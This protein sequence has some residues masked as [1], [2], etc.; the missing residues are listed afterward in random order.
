M[1]L[2]ATENNTILL[3]Q[4]N[5]IGSGVQILASF[6]SGYLLK[7][8]SQISLMMKSTI[9]LGLSGPLI[10]G[11]KFSPVFWAV[12]YSLTLALISIINCS[13]NA[14]WQKCSPPDLQGTIFG[15]RRMVSS[16]IAPLGAL[17]AG[18][19]LAFTFTS[20]NSGF[21]ESGYQIIFIVSGVFISLIGVVGSSLNFLKQTESSLLLVNE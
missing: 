6:L 5:S 1:I 11:L 15:F 9:L 13:N 19:F 12:G 16:A 17:L 14:F 7:P 20:N 3:G 4:I 10:M 2:S 8:V 21:F 18:P